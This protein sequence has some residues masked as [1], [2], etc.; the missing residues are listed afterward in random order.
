MHEDYLIL[1]KMWRARTLLVFYTRGTVG[2]SF[3]RG[4]AMRLLFENATVLHS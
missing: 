1:T 4:R 3:K 2:M